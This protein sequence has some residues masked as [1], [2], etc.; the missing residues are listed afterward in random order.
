MNKISLNALIQTAFLILLVLLTGVQIVQANELDDLKKEIQH[1]RQRVSQLRIDMQRNDRLLKEAIKALENQATNTPQLTS[2]PVNPTSGDVLPAQRP[3]V[4]SSKTPDRVDSSSPTYQQL[5]QQV[6]QKNQIIRRLEE[7][8]QALN[9]TSTPLTTADKNT[10]EALSNRP[11]TSLEDTQQANRLY[12]EGI[13]LLS[14]SD[15]TSAQQKFAQIIQNYPSSGRLP[16]AK[17]WL[18]ETLYFQERFEA[19]FIQYQQLINTY[20]DHEKSGIALLKSGLVKMETEQYNEAK[21]WFNQVLK[22]YP[23]SKIANEAT[24]KLGLIKILEKQ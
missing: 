11:L 13:Q 14:K 6:Q 17:Y 23:N 1:L 24:H 19:S 3:L 5:L 10:A 4:E 8:L 2:T 18:A 7:R 16:D 15:Y 12:D 20:P 9:Q 22:R 21:I